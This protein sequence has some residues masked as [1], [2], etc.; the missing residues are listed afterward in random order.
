MTETASEILAK[1][2]DSFVN[3]KLHV[4]FFFFFFY[5]QP[6]NF[7]PRLTLAYSVPFAQFVKIVVA[8]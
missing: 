3:N 2:F 1:C 5:R 8:H 4:F 7:K 6:S